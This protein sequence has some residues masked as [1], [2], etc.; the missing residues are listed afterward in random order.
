MDSFDKLAIS[1]KF[2]LRHPRTGT[3]LYT[4]DHSK[5]PQVN[6]IREPIQKYVERIAHTR[7]HYKDLV[8]L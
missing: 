3:V 6:I 4:A 8:R 2:V 7:T 1:D 5:E